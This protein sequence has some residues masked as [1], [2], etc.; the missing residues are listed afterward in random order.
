[1]AV[2]YL[3]NGHCYASA[4]EA[5]DA[6]FSAFT[7]VI[8]AGATSYATLYAKVSGVWYARG[9]SINSSGIWTLRYNSV[10]PVPI[11][12]TC[13]PVSSFTDGMT[14]GWGVAAAMVAVY[15]VNLIRRSLGVGR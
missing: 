4:N 15:A 11:F 5:A 1:M 13:D 3:Y 7:P 12:P 9:Y 8:N 6:Y 14:L 2:G 10:S